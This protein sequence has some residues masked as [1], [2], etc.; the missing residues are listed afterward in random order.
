MF[1]KLHEAARAR[2]AI[3]AVFFANGCGL[4]LWAGHI[5][6]VR[7][8]LGLS[9][10][11]LA[12]A[13]LAM[14]AGAMLLM[15]MMGWLANRFGSRACTLVAGLAF[16]LLLALPLAAPSLPLLIAATFLLGAANGS[17]DVAMSTHGTAVEAAL[18][19]PIMSSVNGF[20]S[21]GGVA[22]AGLAGLLLAM[23]GPPVLPLALAGGALALL[24]ALAGPFLLRESQERD[25]AG[26]G[27]HGF[28]LPTGAAA[29]LGVLA[30]LSVLAEWAML[31]WSAIYL[32]DVLFAPASLAAFG[33]A[34]FS[35]AMMLG[36][37]SGDTLVGRL[38]ARRVLAL[39]GALVAPA[40]SWSRPPAG[41]PWRWR[42]SRS[43]ASACP[44]CSRS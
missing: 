34:A 30:L 10:S 39:S 21:L 18:G 22:G 43:P 9:K 26:E 1:P 15:P 32:A 16:T 8:G 35:A 28:R 24:I 13:L 25:E 6:L 11:R 4:G 42:A 31:D 20:F 23:E 44:T 5:P 40:S 19:R 38:G 17:L 37:F 3:G 27:G 29:V 36:R 2:V 41:P 33:F 14:A 7:R 12:L